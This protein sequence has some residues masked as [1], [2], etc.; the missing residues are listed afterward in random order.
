MEESNVERFIGSTAIWAI[1]TAFGLPYRV[2]LTTTSFE[3]AKL[4]FNKSRVV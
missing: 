4:R 2:P 1:K 3:I